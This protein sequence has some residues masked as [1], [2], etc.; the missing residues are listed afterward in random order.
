ML[1][2]FWT[3][4]F[5]LDGRNVPGMNRRMPRRRIR[6]SIALAGV[7]PLLLL[8]AA[9]ALFGGAGDTSAQSATDYDTNNNN[10]IDITTLAQIDAIRHDLDG[11]GDPASGG[12]AA[13][14]TAFPS[15]EAGAAGRMGCPATCAGYELLN[16]LDFNTDGSSDNS[17]DAPYAN[18]SPIGD[19]AAPYTA[20]FNGNGHSIAN[21]AISAGSGVTNVGLF[22]RVTGGTVSGV[23]LLDA[24]VT[25]AADANL[26]AGALAGALAGGGTI[27]ASWATGSVES[28]SSTSQPKSIGGLV[29]LA[30]GP[31]RASS[32]D[33]A[34][35][36]VSSANSVNV[37][38][39]VG[40]LSNRPLTASYATGAVVGGSGGSS[41]TGLL[42]GYAYGSG[43]IVTASYATGT[44]AG[45]GASNGLVGYLDEGATVTASY[46]DTTSSGIP[47][48]ADDNAPEGKKTYEL[49]A[50]TGYGSTSTP[51]IYFSFNVDVDNA[52]NDNDYTTGPDDPWDF[53]TDAQYPVLKYGTLATD[54]TAQ[55]NRQS[56]IS[57]A[58]T[59]SALTVSSPFMLS[60]AFAS[61]TL[62]YTA[63]LPASNPSAITI[64]ATT[65]AAVADVSFSAVA[66]GVTVADDA[67]L[68]AA[69]HQ[70]T[71]AGLPTVITISVTGEDGST[72][73][74]TIIITGYNTDADS[75]IEVR[76]LAQLN[77]IRYDLNGDGAADDTANN[78]A[79]AAAF[80]GLSAGLDCPSSGCT[81]YEQK[82]NL[83]FNTDGSSDNSADAPYANWLPIGDSTAPYTADFD[84]N[85]YGIANLAINAGSGVKN[86]GLFG[87]VTGDI[88]GV[89]LPDASVTGAADSNLYAGALVGS[90]AGGG[91]VT[92]SWSTGSVTSTSRTNQP[93][94]IGGL[95]GWAAGPVRASYADVTVTAVSYVNGIN[96]GGLVGYLQN[97]P[98]TASYATG[99][100][101]GGSGRSSSTGLLVGAA[102]DSGA[103][104]TASYATGTAAGTGASNGLVGVLDNSAAVTDSYWD[105]TTSGISGGGARTTDALQSPTTYAGI[106]ANWNVDV[107]DDS[108]TGDA[109]G[110][111]DP[112]HF[113]ASNQYPILKYQQDGAGIARQR[114]SSVANSVDYDDDNDNLID[115]RT[116]AQLD[117]IRY[118]LNGDGVSVWGDGALQYANAF[119]G[120]TAGMGCPAACAGYELRAN[121][122]FNT[123]GSSDNSADAPYANWTPIGT[124]AAPYTATFQGNNHDI[125]NLT[126][127]STGIDRVGL[128]GSVAGAIEGVT[129]TGVSITAAYT[130]SNAYDVGGLV[131]YIKGTVRSSAAAG[132]VGVTAG[133]TAYGNVGGLAGRAGN[134]SRIAASYATVNVA[135]TATSTATTTDNIGGLVGII[136]GDASNPSSL[137]ASYATGSV[138]ASSTDTDAGGLVGDV[139]Q[140][141][142]LACYATGTVTG[143]SG[144]TRGLIDTIDSSATVTDSYWDLT[145]SGIADDADNDAPEGKTT[146]ALQSPTA[147]GA[148][149]IYSAWNVDVDGD[150]NSDDPWHFGAASQ[151]P[152]L[153]Y[154]RDAVAIDRQ[155]GS[156]IANSVDYD[157][158]NDN[159]IDV[160]TL[161]QLD[162]IRYDADGNGAVAKGS[163]SVQYAAAFPGLSVG[164]G[165]PGT[166][167][168]YELTADLDFDTSGSDGVADAPYANWTP[169]PTYR[170]YFDGNGH[171]ISNLA[172]NSGA[173]SAQLGLFGE[174]ARGGTIS[175]VGLINPTVSG[176]ASYQLTGALA[177]RNRGTISAVFTRGGSVAASGDTVPVTGGLVGYNLGIIFASYSTTA[178]SRTASDGAT[179]G[180]VGANNGLLI[181]SYAASSVTGGGGNND[182]HCLAQGGGSTR[183]SYYDSTLCPHGGHGG[184]AKTTRELQRPTSYSGIYS[185]WNVDIVI[186]SG[187][188]WDFGY[189]FQ[190]PALRY[191]GMDMLQQGRDTIALSTDAVNLDEGD[192][193]AY[194]VRLGGPP[195]APVTVTV[196]SD[197]ADVIIDDGDGTFG[198]SATLN[199][200]TTNWNRAQTIT[201]KAV[202]DA[203][204]SDSTAALTHRA[205]GAGSGFEDVT[206]SLP[207]AV[208][209][210]TTSS[211]VLTRSG[212]AATALGITEQATPSVT[213]DVALSNRPTANVTVT[214]T[215]PNTP[216]NSVAVNVASGTFGSA[217][218]L[219]FTPENYAAAQ[220][221]TIQAPDD[222]ND[223]NETLTLSHVAS[224]A[225]ASSSSY[226]G[227]SKNLTLNVTDDDVPNI[228]LSEPALTIDEDDDSGESYTVRLAVAPT[229]D[230]AVTVSVSGNL[231]IDGTDS[232]NDFTPSETLTF[233]PTDYG[234]KTVNVKAGSDDYL[235]DDTTPTISH[236]AASAAGDYSGKT[237]ALSVTIKNTDTGALVLSETA[238]TV[239]EGDDAGATYT[240]KLSHR[241]WDTVTVTGAS[242][243]GEAI[244]TPD[245][246][247]FNAANWNTA[248]TVTVKAVP[249]DDRTDDSDTITHTASATGGY[250]AAA[251]APVSVAVRDTTAPVIRLSTTTLDIIEGSSDTYNVQLDAAPV[252]T[253]TIAIAV[254]SG[255]TAVDVSPSSLTFTA[256][257]FG[258]R[259]VTVTTTAD[260][261]G[262]H[263]A[264]ALLHTPTIR[265]VASDVTLLPLL[266][267]EPGGATSSPIIITPPTTGTLTYTIHG[268]TL[269]VER[270]MDVPEGVVIRTVQGVNTDLTITLSSA[271]GSLPTELSSYTL[272]GTTLVDVS[273]SETPSGGLSICL[274]LP[275]GDGSATPR[276]LH[277]RSGSWHPVAST[278]IDGKVCGTVSS[279]SPFIA[280]R[281]N[282]NPTTPTTGG[283]PAGGSAAPTG[284]TTVVGGGARSGGGGGGGGG[285]GLPAPRPTTPR[286]TPAPAPALPTP[287]PTPTPAPARPAPTPAPTP[288]P[289]LAPTPTAL[290]PTQPPPVAAAIR[291]PA[292]IG[293]LTFSN[294]N[295]APGSGIIVQFLLAN[296]GAVTA[297]YRL[298]LEVAG[299][300]VQQQTVTIAPGAIQDLR[301]P[302]I[303]PDTRS[304]VT[305][306][307][308]NQTKTATLTP[309]IPVSAPATG[310]ET[311]T[312]AVA[313][314]GGGAP[315]LLIGLIAVIA[316]AI[317]G[318]G[319][320][321]LLRRR[322]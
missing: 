179:G 190:Y 173:G 64:N 53:G 41:N 298:I 300:T 312:P 5:G 240:V 268:H 163:D 58:N 71:I 205:A 56:T 32:A 266:L 146:T 197:N 229:T 95:V 45:A 150:T 151:Y 285:G 132:T 296:P 306:R 191:A 19:F 171:T 226:A 13:Y 28:T 158:D 311:A 273:V 119:P 141:T 161:A 92:A 77:A 319:G 209:D 90:L 310:A 263:D 29:G 86:V 120:L 203:D 228:L 67:D 17:A 288:V 242:D 94:Y 50:P 271:T 85:G 204:L 254:A 144:T 112:W 125:A 10:L 134:G 216:A 78:A 117:A 222:G 261:D 284:P 153:K 169:I 262:E 65:T 250:T 244:A 314:A 279:F 223:V 155:R 172:V 165:C 159:R 96:A 251:T 111:D 265:G 187:N 315:W 107:D 283:G 27:T 55:F 99:A 43:A 166:C 202:S 109:D 76:T 135:L 20:N 1:V 127:N 177:A 291:L 243:N 218:T 63:T 30:A 148:T 39:L 122:D 217:Q 126:I 156:T 16:S 297:E 84:G 152:I 123:D 74:Y 104:I 193:I 139:G 178:V 175:A 8:L 70:V 293:D 9:L 259:P 207:V 220:T 246:L 196:N 295:P 18:W 227:I 57:T 7:V 275:Q 82:A 83:D 272:D 189:D 320:A 106:Y 154:D 299:E 130:G 305:V 61:N 3:R 180:M 235:A 44:A 241:P 304:Q 245:P 276:L 219:N 215:V 230:V 21:L 253:T 302:I 131:G 183:A 224:D 287:A 318:G 80:P 14:D 282:P 38:G 79:Y 185:D 201:V 147:Y 68:I 37:G 98:V 33:V 198:R 184:T 149:G 51:T 247:I 75:L 143:T 176:T 62:N 42:V 233:S 103:V 210:V 97:H 274:P 225:T 307:V 59:L 142:V 290:P 140:V 47:D 168:G 278:L 40:Y 72:T 301:L 60:P 280:A 6:I 237:A 309:A 313:P 121:L 181:L 2:R 87:R 167:A 137:T 129:V 258:A 308:D 133:G 31:V 160:S 91:A 100:V 108:S 292:I 192:D 73:D 11:N 69:G 66:N 321:L 157:D 257:D 52:D 199:F 46:W 188:P 260:A 249:D 124:A 236:T 4:S 256:A 22:G 317:I 289:T 23:G 195:H 136:D 174:L 206:A 286:S 114:G 115:V 12:T 170:A 277:Y 101:A 89:G 213:Y 25:A 212:G 211:I 102:Y 34:V 182:V 238:H 26:Y 49:R 232:D 214:V 36:A 162:A 35:T 48:D 303:T 88:S 231:V 116:L 186:S 267:R 234:A 322:G 110:N 248:Q 118:D 270:T 208:N 15:R 138:A 24:S 128:F 81:G 54:T 200:S 145:S 255:N 105:A 316:L 93:K 281:L 252:A 264:S 221:V 164:M 294:P 269:T 239:T 113:G 194:R